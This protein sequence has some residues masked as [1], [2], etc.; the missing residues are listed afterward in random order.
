MRRINDE[1]LAK[2]KQ[3]EGLVLFAYDDFDPPNA[4]RKIMP[5]DVV[6]GTLTIGYGSTGPHVKPGLEWTERQ[7]EH[8]LRVDLMRFE[9]AVSRLVTVPLTDNQF[10]A[11]VSFAFNVGVSA[12]Q[13]ST[14]LR[15]LNAGDYDA[16]PGEL[17]KWTRSKGRV[18]QGLV[19]RRSAEAGL[20]AKGAFVAS[21]TI[22]TEGSKPR[23]TRSREA[24]GAGVALFGQAA[25]QGAAQIA[26]L[27]DLSDTLRL[28]FVAL[29][30]LGVGIA[31]WGAWDRIREQRA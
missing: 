10:S 5:G 24:V 19:N 28:V 22:P 16:V 21:N 13:K 14:L 31:L 11:L 23:L 9:N 3:W 30:I 20:W 7:A 18:M 1:G 29:T 12:F 6:R 4:R 15:R 26:P 17:M 25:E 27:A 2:L 8:G